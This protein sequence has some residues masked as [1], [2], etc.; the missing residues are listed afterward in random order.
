MDSGIK[1][2]FL[3]RL[4][5]FFSR[6]YVTTGKKVDSLIM[7]INVMTVLFNTFSA[8]DEITRH[9][10][11][12]TIADDE[13]TRQKVIINLTLTRHISRTTH[14]RKMED[15]SLEAPA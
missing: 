15:H 9:G 8:D 1:S 10:G 7:R 3:S 5:Y 13:I 4:S 12:L 11:F 2:Y 14:C 6:R